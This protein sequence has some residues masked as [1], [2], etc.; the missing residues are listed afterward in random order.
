MQI[1]GGDGGRVRADGVFFFRVVDRCGDRL[2]GILG[3]IYVKDLS[4]FAKRFGAERGNSGNWSR[5]VSPH[6]INLAYGE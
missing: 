5:P 1:G 2:D 6:C 3:V 4:V